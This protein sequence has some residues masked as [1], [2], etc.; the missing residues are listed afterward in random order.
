MRLVHISDIQIRLFR[1]LKEFGDHFDNLYVSV[2]DQSPDYIVIAGDLLH[3]KSQLSAEQINLFVEFLNNLSQIAPLVIIPGNHD[4]LLN[5]LS[6]MDA[7]TPIVKAMN[8]EN[9]HYFKDSGVYPLEGVNF[10]VF[11]CFDELWPTKQ[12][13]PTGI[14]VGLFH[15]MIDGAFLQNDTPVE[16]SPYRLEYFFGL[17]DYLLLG[18]IHKDQFLDPQKKAAYCGSLIQQSYGESVRKGYLV[19]DIES[20]SKHSVKFIELPKICPFYTLRL[21]DSLMIPVRD[22]I[23]KKS[24]IRIFSRQLTLFEKKN[25][26]DRIN[27]LYDPH[28]LTFA[29][30]FSIYRQEIKM[31]SLTG[32]KIENIDDLVI[33]ERLIKDFLL[34]SYDLS[35]DQLSRIFDLNKIYNIRSREK[36]DTLRNIQ[37]FFTRMSFYNLFSYG[38]NNEFDF[39]KKRGIVGI[40]GK[41][42]VGKSSL[43]VD[44]PLYILCNK[45][46]KRG[47]VKND[48]IINENKDSCGGEIA[49]QAGKDTHIISRATQVYVKGRKDD[50]SPILQGKTDVSYKIITED[51][52]EEN[53]DAEKRQDTDQIIRK[54]F[55]TI[56]DFLSTSFASQWQLLGLIESGGTERLKQIGRYFDIDIFSQKH[57]MANDDWKHT[58]GQLK[59]YEG[60]NFESELSEQRTKLEQIVDKFSEKQREKD[61]FVETLGLLQDKKSVLCSNIV[62]TD[63]KPLRS[64]DNVGLEISKKEQEINKLNKKKVCIDI[65]INKKEKFD[66]EN[67]RKDKSIW[68][69]IN[70]ILNTA[71]EME[72]GC[73]CSHDDGCP[74]HI[75]IETLRNEAK[76]LRKNIFLSEEEVNR[77]ISTWEGIIIPDQV[78]DKI[79]I[80]RQELKKFADRK[81]FLSKN[82]NNIQRNMEIHE[83]ILEVDKKIEDI[84]KRIFTIDTEIFGISSLEGRTKGFIDEIEKCSKNFEKIK[85]EYDVFSY[86]LMSMSKEGIVK[87]IISDNLNIINEGIRK[88]LS[89]SV[90]FS[91]ELDSDEDGKAIE[92]YFS[93]EKSKRRRIEL[94][95][96]ME[97]SIAAIALRAALISVT[98]LPKSNIIVFDEPFFAL[99]PEYLDAVIQI[100]EYL[101]GL[102]DSVILITHLDELKDIAD[103]VIEVGRDDQGY[104]RI[105]N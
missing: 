13:I 77:E 21:G 83:E 55:G 97:K 80:A 95:S 84:Q 66:I 98:T 101:K 64:D 60:R 54:K 61:G 3:N 99:D 20:K 28:V 78:D 11:S 105:E 59:L 42:A 74:L 31:S 18:D 58:K 5:N 24:R 104:S 63:F 89:K 19:W 16:A 17:V 57:K 6:R 72:N 10:V 56:D 46:S 30:T 1:R 71:K 45:T 67:L 27:D 70:T 62:F 75:K 68:K 79:V 65:L 50:G 53:L 25:I 52:E 26:T 39:M 2:R 93:S 9:I 69:K 51:G 103:H 41:S 81:S 44:I 15:G 91:V 85:A 48:L 29:D 14:N 100:F 88:I 4:G 43:A 38:E 34:S 86:F 37:Y 8:K 23:Q 32:E 36:D 33:Q 90:G 102:F 73:G 87:K 96:G 22:D 94:C 76:E 47:V 40:F 92:I 7:I 49:I 35:D 82:K 12:E